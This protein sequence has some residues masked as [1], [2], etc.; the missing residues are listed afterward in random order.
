[1]A[2]HRNGS[3]IY[4]FK[5]ELEM[6]THWQIGWEREWGETNVEIDPP[7][8]LSGKTK[9]HF[10]MLAEKKAAPGQRKER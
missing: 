8:T 4:F 5:A 9:R 10:Q 3:V 7:L 2:S 1:M 6:N